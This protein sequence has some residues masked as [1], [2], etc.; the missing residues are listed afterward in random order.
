MKNA[1]LKM[2]SFIRV[3]GNVSARLFLWCIVVIFTVLILSQIAFW[4]ALTWIETKSGQNYIEALLGSELKGSGYRVDIDGL[5]YLMPTHLYLGNIT[6]YQ[7]DEEFVSM[8]GVALN[9]G[10]FPLENK[11]LRL[12]L[13]M[14]ALTLSPVTAAPPA[15]VTEAGQISPVIVAPMVLPDLYFTSIDVNDIAIKRLILKDKT[16]GNDVILS[17][18]LTGRVK[19]IGA[20]VDFDL[21][22][23]DNMNGAPSFMPREMRIDGNYHTRDAA[24]S[25]KMLK[26]IAPDYSVIADGAAIFKIGEV[27]HFNVKAN[28]SL[29]D[30]LSPV[31]MD[32]SLENI[33][34][35]PANI[36]LSGG[37]K[38]HKISLKARLTAKGDD[39]DLKGLSVN[40]PGFTASG[41]VSYQLSHAIARGQVK[42]RLDSL[43]PYQSFI[44]GGHNLAPLSFTLGLDGGTNGQVARI[45]A[46]SAKY[47]NAE[48]GFSLFDL[49]LDAVLTP[50]EV[51]LNSFSAHD[52]TGGD[53]KLSGVVGLT[54]SSID[55]ALKANNIHAL[56][57]GI[58]DGILDLDLSAKGT[59]EQYVVRGKIMPQKIDIRLPE[60]FT[61]E[62]PSLD[63]V[64]LGE[65]SNLQSQDFAKSVLIDIILD[66]PSQIFVRGWGLDA[67]FGGKI[68]IKGALDDAQYDGALK[69]IRG[70]YNDFGK[71]FKLPRGSLIFDGSV[72]PY[73][74]LD[75][76]A[77]TKAGDITAQ[78]EITGNA[79]K[80]ELGF[81]SKPAL[82]EDEVLSHILFGK[83]MDN[84]S[85]FQAVKLAQTLARISGNG[86]GSLS[87]FDPVDTLRSGVGLDDLRVE[88]DESGGASVGAGK[89]LSENVYLEFE[90]GSEEG[91]G[92]ATIEIE[93]TPNITIESEIG[94]DAQGGG[95]VFWKY[96]Y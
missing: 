71:N 20:R 6:I 21:S 14:D 85:A 55:M 67:E 2:M 3:L 25:L 70:R 18:T 92:G 5:S 27:F 89:Y 15:T 50:Q 83:K 76:L 43:T 88:T 26:V 69:I 72:P 13:N 40:L 51:T 38:T 94:Q 87:S 75:I 4:S 45:K 65:E 11:K 42:G 46:S 79:Q 7:G 52:R 41:A 33:D 80:P 93:M 10:V 59:P 62:I 36:S 28:S 95:G 19:L 84:I 57:G 96:D 22:L 23:I 86:G 77:Q 56:K 81:S 31:Q 68:K 9:I 44:G 8:D 17:P 47:E 63:I 37:Y 24:L 12:S 29:I 35:L 53:M 66:A 16:G 61:S 39:I 1:L 82:P 32:L 49:A 54:D 78:I 30:G 34:S 64:K 74:R 91:S 58:A 60:H 90:A 48:I 73:P